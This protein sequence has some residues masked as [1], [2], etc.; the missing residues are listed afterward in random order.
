MLSTF[1]AGLAVYFKI[2]AVIAI[3]SFVWFKAEPFFKK[4]ASFK[5]GYFDLPIS[6][7]FL[8]A[9][10]IMLIALAYH[11]ILEVIERVRRYRQKRRK[12]VGK[13]GLEPTRHF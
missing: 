7:A 12:L 3:I 13:V 9:W 5:H 11:S 2:G 1:L 8:F 6:I 4:Q 10:P